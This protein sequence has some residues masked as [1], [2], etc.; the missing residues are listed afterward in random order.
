MRGGRV[1]AAALI[2]SAARHEV[3]RILGAGYQTHLTKP[4]DP[5]AL[6]AAVAKLAARQL[7]GNAAP[8][9]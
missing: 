4:V 8:H 6:V 2:D 5:G 9:A 1:P 3:K 7:K